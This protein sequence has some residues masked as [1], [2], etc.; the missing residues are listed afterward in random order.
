MKSITC[1]GCFVILACTAV[2][3]FGEIRLLGQP[4]A[5]SLSA[6]PGIMYGTAYEIVYRN[7]SSGDYLSEL[8]WE[9]KPLWYLGFNV[10]FGPRD[11]LRRWGISAELAVKAGLPMKT[12]TMEDRDWLTPCT[13]PG[14]LTNFSSH[15]NKTRAAVLTDLDFAFSMPFKNFFFNALFSLDYIFLNM[16]A[17]NGYVQYGPNYP[18]VSR[19]APY[20]PWNPSWKKDPMSGTGITYIQ[21]W[22][23]FSPGIGLGAVFG[24][25]TLAGSFK[26]TPFVLCIAIDHHILRDLVITDYM[27]G[28]FAL[29]PA[30][31]I[32]VELTK[33]MSAGLSVRYRHIAKTRGDTVIDEK[34]KD[35]Y[36]ASNAAGAGLQ[37]F[38]GGLYFKVRL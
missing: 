9:L 13:V 3:A 1:F 22:I 17:R 5:F 21:H 16:E 19:T 23:L 11:I 36:T 6:G 18:S 30:L 37:F 15:D 26:I 4:Y 2:P 35:T 32:D 38:D 12:G 24:P 27:M 7:R 31:N 33:D 34:G 10:S 20:E 14:S 8:Q 25:V 29:E 28:G